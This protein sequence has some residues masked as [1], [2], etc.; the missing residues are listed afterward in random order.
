M[1]TYEGSIVNV[2]VLN[3]ALSTEAAD[4]RNDPPDFMASHATRCM[5]RFEVLTAPTVKNHHLLREDAL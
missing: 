4:V 5:L 2:T 1:N 3:T